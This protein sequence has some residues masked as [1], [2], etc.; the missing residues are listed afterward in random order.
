[1][2]CAY[3]NPANKPP[4]KPRCAGRGPT[5][6]QIKQDNILHRPLPKKEKEQ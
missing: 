2:S 3:G 4:N 1:M 6:K 5:G